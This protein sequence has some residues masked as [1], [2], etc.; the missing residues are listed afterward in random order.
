MSLS[1]SNRSGDDRNGTWHIMDPCCS[2]LA[3]WRW[4]LRVKW[5]YQCFMNVLLWATW[6]EVSV[7]WE[8][9]RVK[10]LR[11]IAELRV[12]KRIEV[13]AFTMNL[14]CSAPA[15]WGLRIHMLFVSFERKKINPVLIEICR[16]AVENQ[17]IMYVVSRCSRSNTP[18]LKQ[19]PNS[20][21]KL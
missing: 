4:N 8:V 12:Y 17:Y 7:C 5:S 16:Y 20:D 21:P 9:G 2:L 6:I 13:L 15:I 18:R 14:C 10:Q 11:N 19:L 1:H 3:E